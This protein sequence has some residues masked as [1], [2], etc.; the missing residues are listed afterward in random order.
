MNISQLNLIYKVEM[1]FCLFLFVCSY[2][3]QFHISEAIS[4]KL[5][6]HLLLGLEDIVRYVWTCNIAPS[7]PF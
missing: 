4:T 5:C 7:A 6:T 2:L 1:V 3:I